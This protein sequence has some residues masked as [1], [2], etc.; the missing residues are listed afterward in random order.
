ML[1]RM[2]EAPDDESGSKK[3]K[4]VHLSTDQF[5]MPMQCFT[6]QQKDISTL[7]Q[8]H[9]T[10]SSTRSTPSSTDDSANQVPK[11][12]KP[13]DHYN[14]AKYEDIICRPIKPAYDGTA[15]QLVPFLNRLD[16][17]HQDETWLSIFQVEH[18]G[19]N[20]DLIQD[21][22]KIPSTTIITMARN[23]WTSHTLDI[24]KYTFGHP[25]YHSRCLG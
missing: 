13:N 1:C 7:L 14:N 18:D 15:D 11:Q 17:R 6:Q 20:H 12:N 24:D 19:K 16:I 22:A 8:Q 25:T 3:C 23:R 9:N 2:Q 21:F 10:T 4:F 5:T